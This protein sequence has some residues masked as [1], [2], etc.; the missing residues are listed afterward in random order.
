MPVVCASCSIARR[1]D[2]SAAAK[3]IERGSRF[4]SSSQSFSV[5]T[6]V[7]VVAMNTSGER[8][9]GAMGVKSLK[10]SYGK[11]LKIAGFV[12]CPFCVIMIV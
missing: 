12:T 5:F 9:S 2:D 8:A 11:F 4:A 10:V 6:P 1:V 3:V 7:L